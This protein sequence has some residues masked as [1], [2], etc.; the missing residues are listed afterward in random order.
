VTSAAPPVYNGGLVSSFTFA[1]GSNSYVVPSTAFS[2]PEGY[3][4]TYSSNASASGGW[5]TFSPT[6]HTFSAMLDDTDYGPFTAVV[7]ATD[8]LGH[9]VSASFTAY[10]RHI[11][12]PKLLDSYAVASRQNGM[13]MQMVPIDG[14]GDGGGGTGGTGGGGGTGGTTTPAPNIEAYWFTY[15]ADNRVQ[16]TNGT[17]A[18]GQIM[19]KEDSSSSTTAYDAAGNAISHTLVDS[20]GHTQTQRSYY[21][22]RN[23]LA[24]ADYA[25]DVTA[26]GTFRGI[27]EQRV[28]DAAG[29]LLADE[30]FYVLGTTTRVNGGLIKL[31][32]YSETVD[33]GGNDIGG[34]L[35]SAT[36]D[37]YDTDGHRLQEQVFAHTAL[38]QGDGAT[39]TPP[40]TMP[41]VNATSWG[42]MGLQNEVTYKTASGAVG[43]GYDAEGNVIAYEYYDVTA[44]RTDTYTVSYLK[45]DG[46]LEQATAGHSSNSNY[47][48]ATDT[49][50]Y[51]DLGERISIDQ[52]VQLSSGTIADTVRAFAFDGNGQILQRRDGTVSGSTFT[53][54]DGAGT[55]HYAYVNGQQVASVDE[56]GGID[57]VNGLTAFSNT[58]AGASGYVVQFGDTLKSI[59]QAEYGD[60]SL[61][62]VVAQANALNSDDDLVAGQT[63][64]IP[65][66]TTSQNTAST[67]KPY[68]PA[69]I[70]GSTTP[71]LP[72]VAPPP[73]AQHCNALAAIVI[74]AVA[75]IVSFVTYGA[76]SGEMAGWAA[77]ALAGAAGSAASQVAGNAMGTQHG[78]DW[79]QVALGAV[80]GGIGVAVAS[81]LSSSS[82]FGTTFTEGAG[83]NGLN[84]YGNAV[85]GAA[86][87]AGN[88]EASKLLDEPTHFS[89]A[90]L[91]A[92]SVGSAAGGELGSTRADVSAGR[93]GS[94]YWGNIGANA[95][96]DVVTREVSEGLGDHH[97]PSW[98]QVGEDV[99]GNALGNAAVAGISAY[100]AGH[101]QSTASFDAWAKDAW[102]DDRNQAD[103][104]QDGWEQGLGETAFE[105]RAQS[106]IDSSPQLASTDA[107]ST[108]T[109]VY[110]LPDSGNGTAEGGTWVSS[111]GDVYEL[112]S[113][114]GYTSYLE[115]NADG[116]PYLFQQ[117]TVTDL[118]PVAV[119]APPYLAADDPYFSTPDMDQ[120]HALDMQLM[121]VLPGSERWTQ[122][123]QQKAA[124]GLYSTNPVTASQSQLA[125]L[126]LRVGR[127]AQEMRLNG[128]RP[129]P[130]MQD[131]MPSLRAQQAQQAQLSDLGLFLLGTS[132][133]AVLGGTKAEGPVY[134]PAPYM[135][136]YE[137]V[138]VLM[139]AAGGVAGRTVSSTVDAGP[140]GVDLQLTYKDGWTDAQRAEAD[141]KVQILNDSDTVV[142]EVNRSGTSASS[143]YRQ[144]GG[145]VPPGYDV[146]HMVDLQLGGADNVS[147]MWPLNSSVNRSLG[148]QIQWQIKGLP[149][150]TIVNRV[151]IGD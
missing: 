33:Y 111:N 101:Q 66:V 151:T 51:N 18:N 87:Y 105:S 97:V 72:Y 106:L 129:M 32:P 134:E 120:Q 71:V 108:Y 65:Q 140:G 21:D 147:N 107:Y 80:G 14:G 17:L 64:S 48:P 46:Y 93:L 143:R 44:A 83:A 92:S 16:I 60:A 102:A 34:M 47:V 149:P 67:F 3:A 84:A 121:D 13:Q 22:E 75:V 30:Q 144:S 99:F 146:D 122:L 114:P 115:T 28:Y 127:T 77:G 79:G 5:L 2:S 150:G 20:N 23:E 145:L 73:P 135:V 10:A 76:L 53:A 141:A 43:S 78:F 139:E 24:R 38:W 37:H 70:A 110:G 68:N 54:Q 117:H 81:E 136:G 55:H 69:Q 82:T 142:T 6:T 85:A 123:T 42:G 9:S 112:P 95:A 96:Q 130:V 8:S 86:T 133:P 63:L 61:W 124:L 56:A 49:S 138:P 26:G 50:Y 62:Y 131:S 109:G 89:W 132:L 29:H 98:E 45:K 31:D 57:V 40:A 94:N 118:T 91:V 119:T 74:I 39:A 59:A 128:G 15:D 148:S 52:H 19:L 126:Q 100:S 7:T 27:A 58:D 25:V 103:T 137:P 125:A 36:I 35:A 12:N 104:W 1:S 41:A 88:H 11:S 90:G 116:T 113:L 4:L